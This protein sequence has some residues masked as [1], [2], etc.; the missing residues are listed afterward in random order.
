[1]PEEQFTRKYS[2]LKKEHKFELWREGFQGKEKMN[3]NVIQEVECQLRF[4]KKGEKN[5][6]KS[7]HW[8]TLACGPHCL[9]N[10]IPLRSLRHVT[11]F[12][13]ISQYGILKKKTG[14]YLDLNILANAGGITY[15]LNMRLGGMSV[16]GWGVEDSW[17]ESL[18]TSSHFRRQTEWS[19]SGSGPVLPRGKSRD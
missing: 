14:K 8:R 6:N 15:G 12:V 10:G 3:K 11:L 4:G 18:N 2:F 16:K 9:Q 1:M 7:Q 17:H 5:K 13:N 19:T